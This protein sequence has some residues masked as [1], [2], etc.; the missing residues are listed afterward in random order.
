MEGL[1][2]S[3][4]KRRDPILEDLWLEYNFLGRA[5]FA[6]SVAE[7]RLKEACEEYSNCIDHDKKKLAGDEAAIYG[8]KKVAASESYRRELHNKIAIMTVGKLRSGMDGDMAKKIADFA[9]EYA[10]GFKI[11]EE[12]KYER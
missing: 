1:G 9:Y 7:N 12:S 11:G 8:V 5:P 6:G 10:R 2:N 3:S 4:E